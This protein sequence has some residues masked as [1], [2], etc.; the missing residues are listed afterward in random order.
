MKW[1]DTHD[2]KHVN[3]K[4]K[5]KSYNKSKNRF[6]CSIQERGE[7]FVILYAVD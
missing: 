3:L 4:Q 5:K 6:I 7:R 2:A 1:K